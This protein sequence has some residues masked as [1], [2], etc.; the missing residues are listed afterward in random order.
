MTITKQNVLKFFEKPRTQ[1]QLIK[2]F[3]IEDPDNRYGLR[4]RKIIN[5]LLQK[6]LL[7]HI[8]KEKIVRAN[9]QQDTTT[10]D[11]A[12]PVEV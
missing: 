3:K 11:A 2:E 7:A 6:G 9:A 10:V 8:G 12:S 4:I 5:N 1:Q